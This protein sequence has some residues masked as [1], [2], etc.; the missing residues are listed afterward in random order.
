MKNILIIGAQGAGNLGA[1]AMLVSVVNFLS[2]SLNEVKFL[3][4]VTNK[5]N[6]KATYDHLFPHINFEL[7][8]FQPKKLINVYATD[9]SHVVDCVID[10]GG[11]AYANS[12]LRDN[13]RNFIRHAY[14]IRAGTPLIFF[15]QD[16]GPCNSVSSRLLGGLILRRAQHIFARSGASYERLKTD[17]LVKQERISGPYPDCTLRLQSEEVYLEQ[18]LNK[19]VIFSPSAILLNQYGD[20]YL[21]FWRELAKRVP[22]DCDIKFLVHCHTKNGNI[23]DSDVIAMLRKHISGEVFSDVS[24][25]QAKWLLENAQ[26]TITSRYHV[27][28]ASLSSRVLCATVGWNSKYNELLKLYGLENLAFT[29]DEQ[30]PESSA[31]TLMVRLTSHLREGVEPKVGIELKEKVDQSFRVLRECIETC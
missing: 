27:L 10:I 30:D 29:L 17:F 5:V 23:S 20:K 3:F 12:A 19:Y 22:L 4:E 18:P 8:E 6:L 1:E 21:D 28:A 14:H 24:A 26:F 11:L 2:T 31:S 16:F 9:K 25:Q 13:I 7:I 15:T